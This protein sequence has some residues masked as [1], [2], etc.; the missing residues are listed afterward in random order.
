MRLGTLMHQ[1]RHSGGHSRVSNPGLE[2][3]SEVAIWLQSL[4]AGISVFGLAVF[5]QW[6]IYKDWLRE[7]GPVEIAGSIIAAALMFLLVLRTL[8]TAR[9]R[10]IEILD[11]L[12][13]IRSMND[14]I[15][16]SL[17]TIEC[18]TYAA[19][20]HVTDEIRNAVDSIET[21]LSDFVADK[22]LT[23]PEWRIGKSPDESPLA[24]GS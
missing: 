23:K 12:N 16:N 2:V 7:V 3:P 1:L 11:R 4:V 24:N 15:R 18:V 20:P 22:H 17:Q 6:I 9:Q 21:I 8:Q 14:R 10:R 13:V 19:A 5:L